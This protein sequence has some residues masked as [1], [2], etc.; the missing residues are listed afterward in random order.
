MQNLIVD[1]EVPEEN[2]A[3]AYHCICCHNN[4]TTHF[5][6]LQRSQ[7]T[8]PTTQDHTFIP[9][10]CVQFPTSV[11]YLAENKYMLEYNT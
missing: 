11:E 8:A 2:P 1:P 3:Q 9:Y 7:I 5:K 4:I 10:T 6:S